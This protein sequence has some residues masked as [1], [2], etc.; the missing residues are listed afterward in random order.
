MKI[1][2]VFA[3][4]CVIL[5]SFCG[6]AGQTNNSGLYDDTGKWSSR[7][8]GV[9]NYNDVACIDN[10]IAYNTELYVCFYD[11]VTE[12]I[13]TDNLS[14]YEMVFGI[15]A[16]KTYFYVLIGRDSK[17]GN[18]EPCYLKMYTPDGV[19]FKEMEVPFQRMFV[20]DGMIYAY[21]GAGY[22]FEAFD[23]RMGHI[24]ATHYLSEE[25]FLADFPED[26]SDWIQMSGDTL[27]IGSKIFYHYPPDGYMHQKPYY[28][29]DKYLKQIQQFYFTEYIDGELATPPERAMYEENLEGLY[30][31]MKKREKNW[32]TFACE[33][34][35]VMYGVCNIYKSSSGFLTQMDTSGID[36]SISFFYNESTGTLDKIDE[37]E[38]VELIY[39]DGNHVLTHK[40]DGV[41]YTNRTENREEKILDYDGAIGVTVR[42]N[43]LLV[44]KNESYVGNGDEQEF[45]WGKDTRF[46]TKL[47]EADDCE[48]LL[49]QTP[50]VQ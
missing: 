30:A 41:Y 14:D 15:C 26:V 37:Y 3:A 44:R 18:P 40:E 12:N 13:I 2:R 20:S 35:G 11:M 25:K 32:I 47:W 45:Y 23:Q 9:S 17:T 16:G 5:L 19:L 22:D 10:T 43:L 27:Q 24:E 38:N 21:W 42:D 4:I 1:L 33:V 49:L 28:S 48:T 34:D 7:I 6:C 31:L 39:A 50:V 36:Y 8:D 29:D 46:V